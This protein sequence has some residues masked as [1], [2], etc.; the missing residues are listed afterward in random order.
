[1]KDMPLRRGVR[2]EFK[3]QDLWVGV[4]WKKNGPLLDVWICLVPML[5]IHVRWFFKQRFPVVDPGEWGELE[6]DLFPTVW[7]AAAQEPLLGLATTEQLIH[8]LQA[9]VEVGRA[10]LAKEQTLDALS[11]L[12]GFRSRLTPEELAYRTSDSF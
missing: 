7:D 1:M 4:F 3:P 10:G 9:R 5:P 6:E 11:W 8:E 2:I 12:K